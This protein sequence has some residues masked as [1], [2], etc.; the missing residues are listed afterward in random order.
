MF[1]CP[2]PP[3]SSSSTHSSYSLLSFPT[4]YSAFIYSKRLSSSFYY[5]RYYAQ[6]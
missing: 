3:L 5:H 2:S 4:Y 1:F 6:I